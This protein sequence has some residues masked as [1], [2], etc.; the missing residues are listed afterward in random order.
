MEQL[1]QLARLIYQRNHLSHQIAAII[2]RPAEIGHIGEYIAAQIFAVDL[3]TSARQRSSDGF[4]IAPP[5]AGRSVNIKWYAK[6]EGVLD[7]TPSA[8]PDFYLVLA[9]PA[10]RASSSRAA[11]RPLLLT[12][13]Y[14]FEAEQLHTSLLRRGVKLGTATSI[15]RSLWE[16]AEIYPEQRNTVLLLTDEQRQLLAMFGEE[17]AANFKVS[18]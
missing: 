12:S 15:H 9:G 2:G 13:V 3:H 18:A 8:Y 4:F 7:L 6:Q 11:T 14:L 17:A 1:H 10:S 5:L 16:Q